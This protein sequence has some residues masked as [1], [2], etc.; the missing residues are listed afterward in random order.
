VSNFLWPLYGYNAVRTRDFS[1]PKLH[2]PFRR[3]WG[4]QDYA[5]LEFPPVMYRGRLYLV[6]NDGSV[7][8]INAANGHRV[9]Q[10]KAGT[11][12]AA[13]PALDVRRRLVLV[14]L[15][16]V[17]GRTPGD[18]ALVALSMRTGRVVWSRHI[19]AGTESPP[20]VWHNKVYFGDH[21]GNVFA[22]GTQAGRT[23]WRYHATSSVKGGPSISGG[24][25]YF[26]DYAG[27]AYALNAANG[28][29]IW[30]ANTNGTEF[31]FGS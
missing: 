16:S 3:R 4:Y 22:L 17:R 9:W 28:H 1:D 12:A 24:R 30:T 31:G 11:L 15:L 19:A 7:K 2:P 26:G 20:I 25:I 14:P 8:G 27:R 13:S 10:H 5:L 23:R 6:D 18:G 21:A 29:P